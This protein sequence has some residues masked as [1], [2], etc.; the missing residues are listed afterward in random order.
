MNE[1]PELKP[2]ML[3]ECK[4]KR[5][6]YE[7]FLV[8]DSI[9]WSDYE[10]YRLNITSDGDVSLSST[11]IVRDFP[12]WAVA[13]YASRTGTPA[14]SPATIARIADNDE[15]EI[16][17]TLVWQRKKKKSLDVTMEEVCEQFGCEVRIVKEKR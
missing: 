11:H 6:I 16:Q 3:V 7:Y 1:F 14:L 8:V 10:V 12:E 5:D 2:G 9:A 17:R 15:K 13:V 4:N